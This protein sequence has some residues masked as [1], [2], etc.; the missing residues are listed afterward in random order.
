M[1]TE[2][3]LLNKTVREDR[4]EKLTFEKELEGV[5]PGPSGVW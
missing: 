3:D 2:R 4:S 1:G 5:R